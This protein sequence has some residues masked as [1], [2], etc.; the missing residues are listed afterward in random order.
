VHTSRTGRYRA[1]VYLQIA[2]KYYARVGS[3]EGY[4]PTAYAAKASVVGRRNATTV[5]PTLTVRR[6]GALAGTVRAAN[7]AVA[8]GAVVKIVGAAG[9]LFTSRY[10]TDAQ[11]AIAVIGASGRFRLPHLRAGSYRVRVFVVDPSGRTSY[12]LADERRLSIVN[13]RTTRAD[14]TLP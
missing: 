13:Q 5:A 10:D 2:Q 14:V 7:G 9:T 4:A 6:G 12:L 11:H 3:A 1:R 8:E